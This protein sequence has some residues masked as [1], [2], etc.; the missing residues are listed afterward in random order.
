VQQALENDQGQ[1]PVEPSQPYPSGKLHNRTHAEPCRRNE[2][3]ASEETEQVRPEL[4]HLRGPTSPM[5]VSLPSE[6]ARRRDRG[7]GACSRAWWGHRRGRYILLPISTTPRTVPANTGVM[8]GVLRIAVAEVVLHGAEIRALVG[9]VVA[10]G[11]A[12]HVGPNPTELGL[13]AGEPDDVVD[14][15]AGELCLPLG[16][17]QPGPR[18]RRG[19]A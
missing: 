3:E 7:P 18:G 12:E 5:E 17:E 15:P 4:S 9:E 6:S 2:I 19:S 14:G 1:N 13:F 10:A 8:G 11:V 16:H